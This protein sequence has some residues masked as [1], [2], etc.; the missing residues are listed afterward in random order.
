MELRSLFADHISIDGITRG[1]RR[2][3]AG[4]SCIIKNLA[5]RCQS[6][7]RARSA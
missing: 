4:A 3:S 7:S 5:L 1:P 6:D 2:R